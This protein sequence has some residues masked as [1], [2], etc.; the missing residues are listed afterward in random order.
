MPRAL[1]QAPGV[2]AS[3]MLCGPTPI[4]CQHSIYHHI[5]AMTSCRRE[6]LCV[7]ELAAKMT[8]CGSLSLS[9]SL[10]PHHVIIRLTNAQTF[11]SRSQNSAPAQNSSCVSCFLVMRGPH[12]PSIWLSLIQPYP[13]TRTGVEYRDTDIRDSECTFS[14]AQL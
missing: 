13:D 2:G 12:I 11:D 6:F 7:H 8:V 3:H 9:S 10:L 14:K 1:N 4:A 5:A